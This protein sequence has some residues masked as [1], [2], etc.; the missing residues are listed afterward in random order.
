MPYELVSR[1]LCVDLQVL[2]MSRFLV[3]LLFAASLL[4]LPGCASTQATADRGNSS[5]VLGTWKYRAMAGSD[6]LDEGVIRITMVK[7]RLQGTLRDARLGTVP[8]DVRYRGSRLSL[9]LDEIRIDGRV[10]NNEYTAYYE[11]PM[12]DVTTSQNFRQNAQRI[13]GS[14]SARRV[15]K[16]GYA[17]PQID[18]GCD[19]LTIESSSRCR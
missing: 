9:R 14:I 17:G 13:N 10:K 12:W 3:P 5:E 18:L 15:H 16:T 6:V 11:R 4:L 8:V 2:L 1:I 7:G 19:P